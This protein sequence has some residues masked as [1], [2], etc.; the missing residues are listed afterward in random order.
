[1]SARHEAAFVRIE[2]ME[3]L[4]PI[5]ADDILLDEIVPA[6]RPWGH[7]IRKGEVLRIVDVEGQ[8]AVDFLCYPADDVTDR[9]SSMNTIKVQG[10]AYVGQGTVLYSDAGEALFTVIADTLGRHD[11]IYGCCSEANNYLRYGVR[12]TPSCYANFQ[13]ILAQ[14]GLDKNAIVSNVNFFMQVPVEPDGGAGIAADVSP[15]GSSVD[16]RAECDVL[17]VLS[18]C[19]QMHNACNGYNPTPVRVIVYRHGTE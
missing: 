9:Y 13:E 12:G 7:V 8:Q 3:T 5:A 16:L 4:G 17:A 11:T 14:F 2:A 10:N 18:N 15:P 19:P 1:M 6:T